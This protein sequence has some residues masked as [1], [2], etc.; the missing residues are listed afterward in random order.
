MGGCSSTN[1]LGSELEKQKSRELD[2]QNEEAHRQEQ[3]KVKLLLLGAG[4]SGKSTVFKQMKLLYGMPLTDEEKRHC[5]PIVHNN[6]VTSIKIL[7][8]QCVEL[9]LKGEVQAVAEFDEIKNI[10]DETPVNPTIGAKI[11]ALWNDPG[12]VATW[13]RR[14]EFQIVESVKF[15]FN[16][17]DRIMADD[18]AVTQQDM[19]YARVRTSGIVEEKYQIDGASFVMYDVGGQRNERKKWIHCFED[20]TAVIFV[21]ALSEYDQSLYEDSS[22]N[23]MIE[24]ISLFDEIVN[25]RFFSNSAIILFLNKKDLFEEKIKRVDIKSV[26]VFKDF[27]G[28]IGD[29]DKGVKY[30]L[31]KFLAVRQQKEKEIYHH[32]TCATDSKNVQVVF[33]ACKDIILKQNI[34][35]SG[36]M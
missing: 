3:E 1:S 13:N 28:G 21:A 7:L 35:G 11:K 34:R 23:R 36:F 30:F 2:A 14:A 15:Y 20:V 32:V 31:S 4:E 12:I 25:N 6:I 27:N 16:E 29:Y 5:T 10:S 26:E 24:A 19:L 33:N 18:Y 9:Q 17:I 22:T 8:E